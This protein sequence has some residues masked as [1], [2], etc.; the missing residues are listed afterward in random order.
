MLQQNHMNN[1][2]QT[3]AMFPRDSNLPETG[4]CFDL[5]CLRQVLLGVDDINSSNET[6]V[7]NELTAIT[8][9]RHQ[10]LSLRQPTQWTAMRGPACVVTVMALSPHVI[11]PMPTNHRACVIHSLS[12]H[13][14]NTH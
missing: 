10:S 5:N 9:W 13:Q 8:V 3:F 4:F 1:I 11:G 2:H 12:P 6:L 14:A 7:N